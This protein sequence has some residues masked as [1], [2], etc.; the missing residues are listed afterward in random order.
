[1]TGETLF[2]WLAGAST[3]QEFVKRLAHAAERKTQEAR[4]AFEEADAGLAL[5]SEVEAA[6]LKLVRDA[7]GSVMN[8]ASPTVLPFKRVIGQR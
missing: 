6:T 1:M 4:Q 7:L 8:Q 3:P 2:A 5:A